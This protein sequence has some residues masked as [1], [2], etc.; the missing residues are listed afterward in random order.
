[1]FKITINLLPPEVTAQ[2]QKKTKFYKIQ[3]AGIVV[4]LTMVFLASLIIALRIL[5]SHNISVAQAN[6][7]QAQQKVA[8]LKDTQASLFLLKDRL[9]VISQYWGVPSKQSDMYSLIDKLI[10]SS[11]VISA[12]IIDKS[13][14]AVFSALAPDSDSLDELIMHLTTKENNDGKIN[15]VSVDSFNRGRDGLYRISFRIKS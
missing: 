11:I 1:M 7:N 3:T 13:G 6:F 2:E 12:I 5:Q 8:D 9:T 14:E 15:Q 4:T 10:P